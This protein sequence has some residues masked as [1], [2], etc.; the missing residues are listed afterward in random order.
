VG[1]I[2]EG[3]GL[4][5]YYEHAGIKLYHGDCRE[6]LPEIEAEA[7]IT[8][9]VWPNC[10]HIFP[11]IDA[12]SLLGQ[13]LSVARV[14]R[15]AIQLGCNSDPRFLACVPRHFPFLRTCYLEYAVIGYLGRIMRDAEVAFVFGDA[16][17]SK[18]GARVMPGRT[19]ATRC[20][21]DKKWSNKARTPEIVAASVATMKHPTQRLIQHVRW[22]CKWFGGAS[23][24]DPFMG[25]GTAALACSGLGI[26][27][28]GIELE[29]RYCEIAAKRL[30]QEVF[31]FNE[32]AEVVE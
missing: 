12:G 9:P 23:V 29:E 26:T 16:P 7:I 17:D 2:A 13:A 21:G 32:A 25:S 15:A 10:E 24:I 30:S 11:G 31:A 22:L 19:I 5:P 6:I 28:T 8:D 1:W 18:P 4:I 27:F 3:P 14:R 20:N